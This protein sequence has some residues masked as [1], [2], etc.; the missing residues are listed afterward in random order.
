MLKDTEKAHLR[1]QEDTWS[2]TED[3]MAQRRTPLQHSFLPYPSIPFP[4]IQDWALVPSRANMTPL[5]L[6]KT[7]GHTKN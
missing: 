7:L 5:V 6:I 2:A 1:L 3:K 4:I